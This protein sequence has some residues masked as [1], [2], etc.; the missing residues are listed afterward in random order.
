MT[1]H[2]PMRLMVG[3]IAAALVLGACG[4]DESGSDLDEFTVSVLSGVFVALKPSTMEGICEDVRRDGT[5][6]SVAQLQA[7]AL[8]PLDGYTA[9]FMLQA[10]CL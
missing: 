1:Y 9:G 10:A 6:P 4:G 5:A 8:D 7:D 2:P 3:V